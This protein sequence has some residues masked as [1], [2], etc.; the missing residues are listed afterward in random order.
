M[1]L[2]AIL[3]GLFVAAL[4]AAPA[5]A[6]PARSGPA[7]PAAPRPAVA[8]APVGTDV[9]PPGIP[10]VYDALS[11]EEREIVQYVIAS[12]KY[13]ERSPFKAIDEPSG[14]KPFLDRAV[15][16]CRSA[17]G[18]SRPKQRASLFYTVSAL[19]RD[20]LEATLRTDGYDT[21]PI[22]DYFEQVRPLVFTGRM[23]V[24]R[25]LN[26]L[27]AY[28]KA[29]GWEFRSEATAAYA[30]N[31]MILL[32]TKEDAGNGFAANTFRD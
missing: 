2:S 31:Y 27:P 15:D 17:Y 26:G 11:T 19:M 6:A 12:N 7:R 16:V 21:S 32:I 14:I 8:P 10:C 1:R 22:I 20:V 3:W 25:A 4:L 28:L 9:P 30:R 5:A 18:W 29:N 23:T 13:A 24:P